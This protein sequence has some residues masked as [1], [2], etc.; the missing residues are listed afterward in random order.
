MP[1]SVLLTHW[2]QLKANLMLSVRQMY[3]APRLLQ[4]PEP[5]SN[6]LPSSSLDLCSIRAPRPPARDRPAEPWATDAKEFLRKRLIGR[7]VEVKMEYTRKVLTRECPRA[8]KGLDKE[9]GQMWEEQK[10]GVQPLL[11]KSLLAH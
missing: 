4:D 6:H 1:G 10:H 7:P 2:H 9:R 11:I 3:A 8:R 5:A